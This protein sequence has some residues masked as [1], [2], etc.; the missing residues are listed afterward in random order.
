[1]SNARKLTIALRSD[2][3]RVRELNEDAVGQAAELGLVVLA[4]GMGGH[5]AGEVA[6]ALAVSTILESMRAG[7]P[8]RAELPAEDSTPEGVLLRRSVEVAHG[9]IREMA[10]S[11][12][13]YEG[14]GTTVV[15][16]LFWNSRIIVAHVGDSRLYRLR[17]NEL[18]QVTR[19]HS[20]IEDLIAKGFYSREEARQNVRRNILT[21]AL[22]SGD[23]IT[24]DVLGEA[25]EAGDIYLLCSDGLTEMVSDEEIRLTLQKF[26]ASLDRA[27]EELVAQANKH[28][29]KDNVS[30]ALVRV[31]QGFLGKSLY[32]SLKAWI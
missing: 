5:N 28:G 1:M 25:A 24:V 4:D 9:A 12:P 13:Q 20:L 14:M 10:D 16:C 19:D 22:G 7:W 23:S 26:S 15:A 8:Y 11:Q 2:K 17:G 3:G 31:E 30:V 27:A 29:G 32:Q 21:R 18:R 6:S